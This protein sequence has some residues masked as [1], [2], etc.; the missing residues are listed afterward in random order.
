MDFDPLEE[1]SENN[2]LIRTPVVRNGKL[3]TA[4]YDEKSWKEWIK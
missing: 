4:G 1:I 3:V 2:L